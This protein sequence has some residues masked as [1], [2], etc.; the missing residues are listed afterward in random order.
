[1][2]LSI[3]FLVTLFSSRA[4]DSINKVTVDTSYTA[5]QHLEDIRGLCNIAQYE[6]PSTPNELENNAKLNRIN[7]FLTKKHATNSRECFLK[8]A[9]P[10]FIAIAF[11]E[12]L[13]LTAIQPQSPAKLDLFYDKLKEIA[14]KRND[15]LLIMEDKNNQQSKV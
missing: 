9:F 7:Q 1:M 13:D 2:F 15:A 3:I 14:Q 6:K 12:D 4:S 8:K 5:Q 10:C 11:K